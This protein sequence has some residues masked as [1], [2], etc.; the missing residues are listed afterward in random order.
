M[1][2][3]P[4][5][6][7]AD[8]SVAATDK[9]ATAAQADTSIRENLRGTLLGKLLN[10]DDEPDKPLIEPLKPSRSRNEDEAKRQDAEEAKKQPEKKTEKNNVL[11][12]EQ[13]RDKAE[14]EEQKPT[15]E[16][17]TEEK[18][19]PKKRKSFQ[20]PAPAQPVDVNQVATAAATA[21]VTAQMELQRRQA[22]EKT[23]TQLPDEIKKDLPV[24]DELHR[25][26]P[27]KYPR[28]LPQRMAK[29][30]KAELDYAL[31]WEAAHEG[32]A[33]NSEE[34]EHADW[35][36]KNQPV[37]EPDDFE[38][39]KI[40]AKARKIIEREVGPRQQ[41]MESQI[42]RQNLEPKLREEA[43]T[44]GVGILKAVYPD[45][46]GKIDEAEL[47]K[48]KEADPIAVEVATDVDN[49]MADAVYRGGLMWNGM[50]NF[51]QNNA[52]H[53]TVKEVFEELESKIQE[54]PPEEMVQR[55]GKRW[56]PSVQFAKLPP[57]QRSGFFTTEYKDL[58]EYIRQFAGPELA[59]KVYAQ[60]KQST[61]SLV[62]KLAPR[63]GYR[64]DVAS[65]T[66]RSQPPTREVTNPLV[67][68]SPTV[69]N[70]ERGATGAPSGNKSGDFMDK[71]FNNMGV[72]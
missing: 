45:F 8:D 50:E 28:D 65:E 1:P 9:P 56:V 42:E 2:T 63:L 55:D 11:R 61:E 58:V 62:E 18:P 30:V 39:A 36:K 66:S 31:K 5:P 7:A 23:A 70:G 67:A 60:R 3:A 33:Y 4:P 21:A 68:A 15:E 19:A 10:P 27:S 52:T 12:T 25:E 14:E 71:F 35:Y 16:K 59:K 26:N 20:P 17:K 47:N 22:E 37:I 46:S 13:P 54:V 6:P 49:M 57:A 34:A 69:T 48:I 43:K 72:R 24:Y 38:E 41:Q 40:A 32:E 29:F 44:L 53:R 51:D 64:K